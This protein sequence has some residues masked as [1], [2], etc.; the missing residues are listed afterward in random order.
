MS[1]RKLGE[2]RSNCG[3][4]FFRSFHGAS[5][6]GTHPSPEG[7]FMQMLT[8]SLRQ[9]EKRTLSLCLC[10]SQG[11]GPLPDVRPGCILCVGVQ[12]PTVP[13]ESIEPAPPWPFPSPFLPVSQGQ[14]RRLGPPCF[15]H[16]PGYCSRG[17]REGLSSSQPLP[18]SFLGVLKQLP[19]AC[20]RPS[21]GQCR[22]CP[23]KAESRGW[24]DW[25]VSLSIRA[26]AALSR[27]MGREGPREL[28]GPP[29]VD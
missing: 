5:C 20:S 12:N 21:S 15:L 28:I 25:E 19:P 10:R 4:G 23:M 9:K 14:A 6:W 8:W 22:P 24:G 16:T 7:K 1:I 18:S 27:R 29:N 11:A 13:T 17:S 2:E 26:G 3:S